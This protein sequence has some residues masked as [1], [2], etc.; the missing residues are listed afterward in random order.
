VDDL[1]YE[2]IHNK[3]A[4]RNE[5]MHKYYCQSRLSPETA[6]AINHYL[7]DQLVE[8]HPGLFVF[9]SFPEHYCLT[10]KN[11]KEHLE[12]EEDWL[13][14]RGNTYLS[15]FDALCSQIQEDLAICQIDG[16]KDWVAAI[17]LCAPNHWAAAEKAGMPFDIVHAPVPGMEKTMKHY[18]KMLWNITQKGPYTRFAW[19]ISSDNRLN[20]HPE[21]PP[22]ID[23][24]YWY[25]RK[26]N[27]KVA[28]LYI[29]VERQNLIGFPLVNA[30][31]FTIR[32][33]FYEVDECSREEKLALLQAIE[34]MSPE[35]LRYKGL[36]GKEAFLR[37]KLS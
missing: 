21:A 25:G 2:Y 33:Y 35:S 24:D 34:S 30:F 1:Y 26:A 37:K 15:L 10:N 5:F 29:R 16:D 3:R 13:T 12:W 11:T 27:E 28:K 4:C 9:E 36:L 32:T 19:G 7:V 6:V 8:E 17:H 18:F 31:L 20:H 23:H 14:V 22:G